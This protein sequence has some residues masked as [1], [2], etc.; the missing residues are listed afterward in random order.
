MAPPGRGRLQQTEST[1]NLGGVAKSLQQWWTGRPSAFVRTPKVTGRTAAPTLY[2][3][4]CVA[5]PVY[6]SLV[7]IARA[8]AGNWMVASWPFLNAVA[9][10]YAF[11]RFIG[12]R[13]AWEDLVAGF[14]IRLA[15][16]QRRA[17]QGTERAPEYL[18]AQENS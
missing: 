3:V 8:Y 10:G 1:I 18:S 14:A 13:Q 7:A 15:W 11:A 12:P 4:M 9:S 2:I 5:I 6:T 16:A 17:D